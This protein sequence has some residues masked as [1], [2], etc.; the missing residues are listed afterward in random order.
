MLLAKRCFLLAHA[1]S[2]AH[3]PAQTKSFLS[4]QQNKNDPGIDPK[5]LKM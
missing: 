2:T 5:A 4:A 3:V 1:L